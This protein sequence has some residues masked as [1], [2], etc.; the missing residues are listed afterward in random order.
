LRRRQGG[1]E[2]EPRIGQRISNVLGV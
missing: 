2:V 1:G